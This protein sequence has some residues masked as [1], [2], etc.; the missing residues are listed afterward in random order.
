MNGLVKQKT[1]KPGTIEDSKAKE[2]MD[3]KGDHIE[4]FRPE[5]CIST[6]YHA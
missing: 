1:G 6:I 4:G 5:W 3:R 2:K